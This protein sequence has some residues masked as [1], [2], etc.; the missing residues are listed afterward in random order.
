[1]EKTKRLLS[2][3]ATVSACRAIT[4]A[5]IS[6]VGDLVRIVE[7][8]HLGDYQYRGQRSID[9]PLLPS[10]TRENSPC[11]DGLAPNESCRDKELHILNEFNTRA[12]AYRTSAP[13]SELELAIL[14]QHH[15]TPTRLLVLTMNPLAALY[16]AVEQD[17]EGPGAD[18]VVWAARGNRYRVSDLPRCKFDKLGE[19]VYFV[20]P[21]H[22]EN[23]AAFQS[24]LFAVWAN[25][26]KAFETVAPPE[27]LWKI[28]VPK[29]KRSTIKW[30]L[31]CVG[32]NRE[33]LFPD[34]DG[35]G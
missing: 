16:F 2:K 27:T 19:G 24:S 30:M 28:T 26:S 6:S 29:G 9:W 18:A 13:R 8:A 7:C 1:M 33:T 32:I 10:L 15:G 35:L 14:A 4:E 12:K 22:D 3:D 23:R 21:D 20:I 25:P 5:T 17:E 11:R 34:L 31:H